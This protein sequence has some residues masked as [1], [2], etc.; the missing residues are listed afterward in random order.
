M[1]ITSGSWAGGIIGPYF[2]KVVANRNVTVNGERYREVISNFFFAL[3]FDLLD[4]WIQQD[5]ATYH[6]TYERRVR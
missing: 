6:T 1:P 4:M 2:F 5:G 3:A